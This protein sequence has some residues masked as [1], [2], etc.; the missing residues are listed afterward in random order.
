VAVVILGI[1]ND[2]EL[3]AILGAVGRQQT[4]TVVQGLLVGHF[5]LTIKLAR[6]SAGVTTQR[7]ANVLLR[8]MLQHV[9]RGHNASQ[10]KR[11]FG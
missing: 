10:F 7:Q 6:I 9:G 4:G 5:I 11:G 2:P 1:G 8:Q 3:R